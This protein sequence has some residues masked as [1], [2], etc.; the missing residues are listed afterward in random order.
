MKTHTQE[1]L[2]L[3]LELHKKWLNKENDGVRANLIDVSLSFANL[4]FADLRYATLNSNNLRYANLTCADLTY[5]NLRDANLSYAN[6]TCADLRGADLRGAN[7]RGTDL[8]GTDL[9][10][11]NLKDANLTDVIGDKIYIKSLQVDKYNISYTSEMLNI[12]CESHLI[13]E[14]RTFDTRTISKMDK[15]ALEWWTKWKPII[16]NIIEISPAKSAK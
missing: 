3:I 6:L 15:Q 10:R 8:R 14:W 13:E 16:M 5:A 4:S 9:I 12:G 7:L 2:N 11:A 1:E